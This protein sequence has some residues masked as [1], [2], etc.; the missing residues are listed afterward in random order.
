MRKCDNCLN[1]RI[2]VSE[3]GYHPVCCLSSKKVM[4]CIS[5]DKDHKVCIVKN[6]KEKNNG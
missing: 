4:E 1:S 5:G 6:N 2:V 3:N